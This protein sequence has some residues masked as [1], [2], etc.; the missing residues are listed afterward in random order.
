MGTIEW[1]VHPPEHLCGIEPL[2]GENDR[3][4]PELP[5]GQHIVVVGVSTSLSPWI[6][7]H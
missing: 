2:F 5:H 6:P 3:N 7:D 4:N 1:I